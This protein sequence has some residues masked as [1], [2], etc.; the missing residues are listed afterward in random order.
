MAALL[1]EED[2]VKDEEIAET[3][4]SY[5]AKL[6]IEQNLDFIISPQEEEDVEV[7]EFEEPESMRK[8]PSWHTVA[9]S[10]QLLDEAN[11]Q[12][13]TFS[14]SRKKE[15]TTHAATPAP[16]LKLMK[17]VHFKPQ[18]KKSRQ[19]RRRHHE[20]E[21][22]HKRKRT[23]SVNNVTVGFDFAESQ[24]QQQQQEIEDR[25]DEQQQQAQADKKKAE[26]QYYL[27]ESL[28]NYSQYFV[29]YDFEKLRRKGKDRQVSVD[30]YGINY[31]KYCS[32]DDVKQ[33]F[34]GKI[35]DTLK[36]NKHVA[37][38]SPRLFVSIAT[39]NR[40]IDLEESIAE[41][42]IELI[43]S[44]VNNMTVMDFQNRNKRTV[45]VASNPDWKR[46]IAE[47]P[48]SQFELKI[49]SINKNDLILH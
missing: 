42:R 14:H 9:R 35:T 18:R 46:L 28:V 6:D 40:T 3:G 25:H 24:S 47:S 10:E 11:E 19:K 23:P 44:I 30:R 22:I 39:P 13:E 15:R 32:L 8:Y 38:K 1:D 21:N 16:P 5:Q 41:S 33:I 7:F 43:E 36:W 12:I 26:R 31:G 37:N 2:E 27:P 45:R 17:S 20:P 34:L 29:K 49:I 48:N 4:P